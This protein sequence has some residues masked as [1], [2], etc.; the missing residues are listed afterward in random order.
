MN[1]RTQLGIVIFGTLVLVGIGSI[2]LLP[3]VIASLPTPYRIR[4][5]QQMLAIVE[6]PLPTALPAPINAELITPLAITIPA[7]NTPTLAPTMTPTSPLP[8]TPIITN[9]AVSDLTPTATTTTT[10]SPTPTYSPT[11][12]P[13]TVNINGLIITPQKFNNCGP[14]NLSIILNYYNHEITQLEVA[15]AIRPL[16]DD[17]N[18]SPWEMRDFVNEQ[19]NLKAAVFYGGDLNLLKQLLADGFPVIIEEG[20]QLRT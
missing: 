17:R 18:V 1:K 8:P 7:I 9:T 4:L 13:A 19:T 16:Y 20:L 14:T 6:T 2:W 3:R 12:S 11:P 5:P 15:D 10:P